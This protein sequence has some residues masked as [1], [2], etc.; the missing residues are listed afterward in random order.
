V[1]LDRP[2][3]PFPDI[4]PFDS[5]N[6][7]VGDEHELY[8]EQVGNP[9]GVPAVVLHGGPGS[10]C[11]PGHR[12]LFD[13]QCFRVVLFDQR[14]V[15]KSRPKG[16]LAANT[17]QHLIADLECIRDALGIERWML[18]GGSWGALL[19]IAY[20]EAYPER[21]S[22]IALR[23]L[24]LGS[25]VETDWAFLRGPR[26]FRPELW[27]SFVARLPEAERRDPLAGYGRRLEDPDP[28]VHGPA[29][30]AWHDYERTLSVLT[31]GQ[32][33]LP[34][35]D[36]TAGTTASKTWLPNTPFF[37][38]H[39]V[40]HG[41]FLAPEQLLRDAGRLEGIP[42][43]VVQGRFDLLCP[44]RTAHALAAR[45]PGCEL[46][47]VEGAGHDAGEPGIGPA[48][49]AAIDRLGRELT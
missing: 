4:K 29:A 40:K 47:I 3:Q 28:A 23:A 36:T 16:S 1:P 25:A 9:E 26:I 44:P 41:F 42:G 17:T 31:P 21:V 32:S 49:M 38:W 10:G 11:N 20:A 35:A 2:P 18:V 34:E 12:R 15:G 5:R 13:P 39:Y 43:I 30:R 22:A 7:A 46:R 45:W 37:E 27:R 14:G 19:A 33:D 8:V 6:L 48:L 24:F